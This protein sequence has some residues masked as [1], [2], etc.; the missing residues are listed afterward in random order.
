MPIIVNSEQGMKPAI[1]SLKKSLMLPSFLSCCS[2]WNKKISRPLLLCDSAPP[3]WRSCTLNWWPHLHL[4]YESWTCGLFR[5]KSI[6]K[7]APISAAIKLSEPQIN[8]A[9]REILLAYSDQYCSPGLEGE[10]GYPQGLRI[11]LFTWGGKEHNT[12]LINTQILVKKKC[13]REARI[14]WAHWAF[15]SWSPSGAV[16]LTSNWHWQSD[17]GS[18][19]GAEG[20]G[21]QPPWR[22]ERNAC[23]TWE[24][25]HYALI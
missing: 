12:R 17:S 3:L 10:R 7:P 19:S 11:C 23:K 18:E 13:H 16:L 24:W 15:H 6:I 2:D 5:F 21:S 14:D 4:S 20:S 25:V 8:L 9:D 1:I 22:K